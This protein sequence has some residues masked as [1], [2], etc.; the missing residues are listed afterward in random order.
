MSKY[1]LQAEAYKYSGVTYKQSQK[2]LQLSPSI[3]DRLHDDGILKLSQLFYNKVFDNNI[4]TNISNSNSNSNS[5]SSGDG[6]QWF[7][8]IFASSTKSE[9][10]DNQ[11]RFLVQTFGGPSLYKEKKGRFTRLAGRHAAYTISHNAAK[12]WIELMIE[13]L[14]EHDISNND[15]VARNALED[16]FTFT[17]HYIVVASTFMKSDQVSVCVCMDVFFLICNVFICTKFITF[18]FELQ[19]SGGTQLDPGRIW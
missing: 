8:N 9:A 11:Y 16:Y 19:L 13:A 14:D 17:S 3:Y 15:I 18:S 7:R 12:R 1:E 10:I 6:Y 5:T 4:S 2:A